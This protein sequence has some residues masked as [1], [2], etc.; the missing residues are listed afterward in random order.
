MVKVGERKERSDKKRE[1][2]PLIP[3]QVKE[4]IHRISHITERPLKDVCE[5]LIVFVLRDKDTINMLAKYFKRSI[6]IDKTYYLGDI[7]VTP[8]SKRITG[9]TVTVSIKF[10][11]NDYETICA[12][13]YALDCTPTRATA[14]LLIAALNN[15]RVVNKFIYE[16]MTEELSIGQMNELRKVLSYVNKHN[17]EHSSWL[18]ALSIIV[19]DIRPSTKKL[20][21]LVEG[22]LKRK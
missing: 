13:A 1:V 8:L 21:E 19:G 22:F 20:Y 4:E 14:I 10:K 16:Y 11:R 15:I 17:D 3:S 6:G 12:L 7:N 9:E 2:K 5:F 18:T